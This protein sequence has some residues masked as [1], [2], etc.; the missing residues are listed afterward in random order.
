MSALRSNPW[1]GLSSYQD[2]KYTDN[3]LKFCGREDDIY[4]LTQMVMGNIFVTLYGKSGIGK[5][6]LL[7]AGVFP[8]LRDAGFLPV[9][10]RLNVEAADCSFQHC[11]VSRLQSLV[12]EGIT[13]K[14]MNVIEMPVDETSQDYLWAYFA[15][16]RFVAEDGRT[17]FPVLAFDQ[18]E[19]VFTKRRK[20]AETLLCQLAFMAD[21]SHSLSP[22]IVDGENYEYDYNFRFIASIREDDLYKL[23]DSIDNCYLIDLKKNRYR[24]RNLTEKGA[25]EVVL[26]P[27]EGLFAEPEKESIVDA[28][29]KKSGDSSEMGI[30]SN[31]LSLIC[32]RLYDEASK[33]GSSSVSL[34]ATQSF[35]KGNPFEKYFIEATSALSDSEMAYIEDKLIDESGRRN[36]ISKRILL[37]HIDNAKELI[38]GNHRILQ[39][40]SSSSGNGEERVEL[41]HDSFCDQL[42]KQKERRARKRRNRQIAGAVAGV[43]VVF[44]IAFALIY[45]MKRREEKML[46]NHSRFVAEKALAIAEEDSYLARKLAVAVLPKDLRHPDRPYTLEAERALREACKYESAVLSGHT[47]YV[48][49]ATYSPDGSEIVSVSRDRTVLIWDSRSG[50]CKRVLSGHMGYVYSA[51]YSPDGSEIVSASGDETIRIWDSRTGEC[52]RVLSLHTWVCSATYSPDG[53]EIVSASADGTVRIWNSRTGECKRVLSGHTDLVQ[54]AIYSPDGSEI[55]SAS[56]DETIRIWDSRTGECKRVLSGH[57]SGVYL[58]T[59]S[60]DG[61]EIVSAL[62]NGIRIWNSR[63]GECMRVLSDHT[64]FVSS[65]TYSPDGSEIVSASADKTVRIWDSRSFECK[66]VL[67]GHTDFVH[68]AT[69]SPDGSE[70]VSA[71][72]DGT[73]RIWDSRTGE[74][75]QLLSGHTKLVHS[76]T[77]SPDGSEIVSASWDE[78]IRIWD[79]R[80]GECKQILSGHTSW[81]NS[82]TYSPDG[83]EIVSASG[84]ETI[85][86][87]DSRTGECK[88][89]LSGHMWVCSA[90]YSPDGSE[91]VSVSLD[92][93]V[94]IWDSR[95]GE[96]KRVLSGH[97]ESVHSATYSP[98]GSEIVSASSDKMIKVWDAEGFREV[99]SWELPSRCN[100]AQ[101]NTDG[102]TIAVACYDGNI[103]LI[104][105]PPLQELIDQTR[106]RF[107]N[108]PLTPEERRQYYLE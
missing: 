35:L 34:A 51:T 64:D 2:P 44:I 89:V 15:R 60:P 46:V 87:W 49:S 38:Y 24:L 106:E 81:V 10:I 92:K 59:Y 45:D 57:T 41:I 6:S 20:E 101:F 32:S 5:T 98:D 17:V 75:K 63:T 48:Y 68:S 33:A 104:D 84:D 94:R 43:L 71:S 8:S 74:C 99:Y 11:I 73:V 4:D 30:S 100:Y 50:E 79:S 93:T 28:I 39:I 12:G 105:F 22:R 7:N 90:T 85:R 77:Y 88:R 91:I 47:E 72:G 67:S 107:K 53:S 18:F 62:W 108:N 31:V 95:S 19:E 54:S 9:G 66:R 103:Y 86:I 29:L 58:A 78:T 1:A 82:A 70:I 96:C 25:R 56:C 21:E 13:V 36:S 80:T 55:V 76:A 3:P 97:T 65:A 102:R 52:K 69:Y 37:N 16:T 26:K 40:L 14:T 42:L 27:G 61:S 23:E 83:S